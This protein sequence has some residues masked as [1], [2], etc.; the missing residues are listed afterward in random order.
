MSDV[1]RIGAI[2]AREV[3]PRDARWE[4]RPSAYRVYFWDFAKPGVFVGEGQ[5]MMAS[6]EFE[7]SGARDVNEVLRWARAHAEDRS[8]TVY[9]VLDNVP[10]RPGPGLVHI[11]GTDPT[12]NPH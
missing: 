11:Y 10:S 4:T 9:A 12:R 5:R 1:P 2:E 8:F 7:L 6:H 3:D